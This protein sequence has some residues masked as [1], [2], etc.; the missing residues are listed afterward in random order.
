MRQLGNLESNNINKN[1]KFKI[2]LN[3]NL[4]VLDLP[5]S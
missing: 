1:S 2:N 5:N 4:K 3:S